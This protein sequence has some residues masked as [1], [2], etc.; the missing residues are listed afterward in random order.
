MAFTLCYFLSVVL[1][2]FLLCRPVEYNWDKSI[3]GICANE[4]LAFFLAGITN[5]II[6]LG[7]IVL[8][9]PILWNLQMAVPRKIAV[10]TM[11]G[12]GAMYVNSLF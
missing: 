8:P 1:E 12:I 7:V 6:D 2:A 3:A 11:F 9:M 10:S 4:Q 5:L